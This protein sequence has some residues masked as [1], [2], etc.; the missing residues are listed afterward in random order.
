MAETLLEATGLTKSWGESFTLGPVDFALA[1]GETVALHGKNG[2]GKTTLLSLLTGNLDATKGEVRVTGKRLTPDTPPLK[3]LV[4]YLPQNPVLPRWATGREILTYAAGL[5]GIAG[6]GPRIDEA[7]VYWDC[8]DYQHKPLQTL[9]H[10]M[11]KRVALALA[12]LADPPVLLLD[13][14]Y[15]GLDVYH[16]KALDDA[17]QRRRDRGQLTLLSTHIAPYTARHCQRVY[18]LEGGK[19]STVDDWGRLGFVE[20]IERIEA[21]FFGAE[22]R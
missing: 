17:M 4:G 15:S 5:H 13:E 6:A 22:R 11:Q 21:Y 2:A 7:Q 10:G 9:S 8:A 3:R 20:R 19:L 12:T 18:M 1:G 16:I 14:P